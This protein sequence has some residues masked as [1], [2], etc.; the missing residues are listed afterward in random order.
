MNFRAFING[1]LDLTGVEALADL[2]GA[3]TSAQRRQALEQF[4]G[5]LGK[6]YNDEVI[7]VLA[8]AV[9]RL[10]AHIDFAEE[11]EVDDQTL[12]QGKNSRSIP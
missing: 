11:H 6:F 5:R 4:D 8:R 10:E 12:K 3:N 9:A 2:I 1:K 7:D